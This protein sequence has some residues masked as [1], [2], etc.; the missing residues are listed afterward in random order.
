MILGVINMSVVLWMMIGGTIGFFTA[1]L[2]KSA[3]KA[4]SFIEKM[5]NGYMPNMLMESS[6]EITPEKPKQQ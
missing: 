3:G 2:C 1:A 6:E 4:D 5:E